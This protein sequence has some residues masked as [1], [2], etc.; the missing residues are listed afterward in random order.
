MEQGLKFLMQDTDLIMTAS[1]G[2]LS[3]WQGGMLVMFGVPYDGNLAQLYRVRKTWKNVSSYIGAY[4]ILA[5]AKDAADKVGSAYAVFEWNGKEIYRKS[6]HMVP[7]L[8]RVKK[9]KET[10]KDPGASYGEADMKC[11]VGLFTIV[12]VRN[13]WSRFNSRAKWILLCKTEKV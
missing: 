10:W 6:R 4:S 2:I 8:V 1:G 9:E 3:V 12:E 11:P 7:Y 13:G 5:N